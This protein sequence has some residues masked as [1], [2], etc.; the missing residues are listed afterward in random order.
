MTDPS[1]PRLDFVQCLHAGGLHRMAYWEWGAP[2][3][4]DVVVCVHGL[5]RQGRDFDQLARAL[6]NRF[7]VICPDVV[8]RGK[9]DWLEQPMLYQLPQYVADMVTLL[10]R[11]KARRVGWVGT[12][13]GGLI[14]IGLAGLKRSPIDTFVLNDIGPSIAP[15]GLQR[16]GSY[17]GQPN[18]F[19]TVA[20]A[21][22][23]L[24]S[25][26]A[27]FGPHTDE[28]WLELS[29]PMVVPH[30]G[31]WRLHYDPGIRAPMAQ[32]APEAA[33]AGEAALWAL[34]DSIAA[35]TLVLRGADSDIL[36]RPTALAMT[37]RGPKASLIELAGV[38]HAAT[39]VH[40]DQIA[41][42]DAFL[43]RHL[44]AHVA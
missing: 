22:T 30:E 37:E 19:A 5:S 10:A 24:A 34:Y 1:Q 43:S 28:E 7:R 23:Y 27:G 42:V 29:R 4:P 40:A 15:G 26:S 16:I 21:A 25:I 8:G 3:N 20:D 38:G 44:A 41:A 9:S 2:D 11:L 14:G 17:V 18:A 13:M 12:S 35:P 32:S 36:A 6:Q 33:R 31:G 39:L